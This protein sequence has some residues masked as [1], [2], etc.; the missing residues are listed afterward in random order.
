MWRASLFVLLL[1]ITAVVPAFQSAADSPKP[2][3]LI[4]IQQGTLPIIVSAPHG[5]RIAV[6]VLAS[7][8]VWKWVSPR[9]I[10]SGTPVTAIRPPCGAETMM[11]NVPF[12]M[13]MRS[14]GL[15]ESAAD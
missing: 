1:A 13:R 14:A 11:G 12:W 7:R 2:A 3:D 8:T 15:G 5:G 6:T 4:L 10:R 9:P